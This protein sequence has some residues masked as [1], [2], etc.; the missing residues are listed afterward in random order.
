MPLSHI[1]PQDREFETKGRGNEGDSGV[2]KDDAASSLKPLNPNSL[3][4]EGKGKGVG[5]V[6]PK[7][8]QRVVGGSKG[9]DSKAVAVPLQTVFMD[10]NSPLGVPQSTSS[11]KNKYDMKV[12][13]LSLFFYQP[14]NLNPNNPNPSPNNPSPNNPNL[15][16]TL[17]IR[18]S[19]RSTKRTNREVRATAVSI[20]SRAA[21]MGT[22][23]LKASPPIPSYL[24]PAPKMKI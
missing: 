9:S 14:N 6:D 1:T 21:N 17:M 8:S 15:T 13:N 12:L 18:R 16:L 11:S 23:H 10:M 19:T 7:T 3:I 2:T 22:T 5:Q 24:L 4:L 20:A